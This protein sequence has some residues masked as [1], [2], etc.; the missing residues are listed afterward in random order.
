MSFIAPHSLTARALVVAPGDLLTITNASREEPVEVHVDGRPSCELPPGEDLHVEFAPLARA[1][2]PAAGRDVLP[3][4]ARALRAALHADEL[5]PDLSTGCAIR[6]EIRPV[7]AGRPSR[8]LHELRVENL[9]LIERAELRLGPGLNVLTGETGA[10]K[11]VLAH[12]LDLLLGGK[13][14]SGIVRP[15]ADGGIRRRGV[16]AA[17]RRCARRWRIGCPPT[18]RSSCWPVACQRRG[19]HARVPRRPQ[20]H[21]G[22]PAGRRR[23]AAVVLRPARAPQA[24][25]GLRAARDPRRLLRGRAGG[26][27]RGVRRRVRARARLGGRLE[28]LRSRAGARDRE[29]DLLE[30]ELREI[31]ARGPERGRGGGAARRARAAAPLEALRAAAAG[32]AAALGGEEDGGAAGGAGRRGVGAG[33]AGAGRPGARRAGRARARALAVEADDLAAELRRYGEAIE[34]PRAGPARRR[35]RSAWRVLERLERKHGGTIAAVLAHAEACRARRDE[36]AGAEEA[37][38]EADG[39]SSRRVR[40][41]AGRARGRAARRAREAAAAGAGRGGARAAR[42]AGD[43]GRRVRGRA[44]SR[45]TATARPAATRWSS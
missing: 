10:G 36:L 11:T 22:R 9:L 18:P 33:G 14:R 12:A 3:P 8:V 37:L 41:R 39:R 43:G 1:A 4:A 34:A 23:G 32:G 38:E 31:E 28:A 19:P 30:W 20:R 24:H 40:A 27:P 5:V 42:R 26:A 15:G 44:A 35:S 13:P 29:L 45:A 16:R 2:R 21:G 25:A 7:A 6:P 17:R